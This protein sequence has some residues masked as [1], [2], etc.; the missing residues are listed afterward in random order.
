M[1]SSDRRGA[2]RKYLEDLRVAVVQGEHSY[3]NQAP[4]NP[5]CLYPEYHFPE[6]V[7]SEL[8]PAYEAVR[9]CFELLQLDPQN[10]CSSRWNPL[11]GV[12]KPGE[13]V[14]IKPNFVLSAHSE[15]GNLF[16]IITH[17]SVIRAIVDYVY[18]A[19]GGE[20][21]I[22]VADAPQM[23]C[24]FSELL[25]KTDLPSIQDLYWRKR[26][27][28]ID[29]LDLRD[30]WLDSKAG[31]PAAFVARRKPLSGDPLGSVAINLANRSEF[32]GLKNND[33]FYGADYNRDE[34]IAH[35]SGEVQE[36]MV[37]RT[38]LSADSLVLVPKLKV[39]KKVGVTLNAKGMV[40]I[41][42][43]K[44]YIVHYTLG[45][46][47]QGGDQFPP[48]V[49]TGNDQLIIHTQR[50]LNDLLLAKKSPILDTLYAAIVRCYRK[51]LK[52]VIGPVKKETMILDGGNWYGNDSAWR[53]V[54]DLMKIAIYADK[55]GTL[56]ELPQRKILSVID[57]ITGGE[58]NGPLTPTENKA[59][60]V[61]AGFNPLAV[62]IVG[63]RL[64]GF[65]WQNLKWI[66]NLL[67]NKYFRFYIDGVSDIRI[68]SNVPEFSAMFCTNN[69]LLDF[70]PHPGWQGHIQV[71]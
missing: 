47:E 54:S 11:L 14:V 56:Q 20:G 46:S 27:F 1:V 53:M 8:N 67:G 13:T 51:L 4:F 62:D 17:P 38:I 35:H 9:R 28:E 61:I 70:T 52:P 23:D 63:T 24:N 31:D 66:E 29:I 50:F 68:V 32:Y 48:H 64:M 7:G 42:T 59:G 65:N 6:E 58:G 57:G 60:V 18:K 10:L 3:S 19:L 39:H 69:R 41:N 44:N 45:P 25:E 55:N 16:S 2:A 40:G 21:K 22:L 12:V 33:K 37:S 49:L 26:K 43:N 15:G 30:F 71:I 34:T 5:Q 36:Y